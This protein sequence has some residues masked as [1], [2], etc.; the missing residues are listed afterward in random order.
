MFLPNEVY[1]SER[2]GHSKPGKEFYEY[3]LNSINVKPEECMMVGDNYSND[4]KGAKQCGIFTCWV[5]HKE[6]SVKTTADIAF[7]LLYTSR[8]V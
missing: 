3:I 8:C 6:T 4:I 2:I 7:C 5:D 1:I